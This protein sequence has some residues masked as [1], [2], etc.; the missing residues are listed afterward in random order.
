M[1][2]FVKLLAVLLLLMSGA[3]PSRAEG[4]PVSF[5]G[6]RINLY[7]GFSFRAISLNDLHIGT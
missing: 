2:A 7:I 5:A 1:R 3:E 4:A 6:K